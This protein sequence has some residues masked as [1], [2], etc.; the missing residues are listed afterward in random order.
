MTEGARL[1]L[2]VPEGMARAI[3]YAFLVSEIHPF[4]DGNG[5]L[6]RLLMNAELTRVG[7]ARVI[8]P[9]LFHPQYVDCARALTRKNDPT[10]FVRSIVKMVHWCNQFDYSDIDALIQA[11][12][13]T[14][15][16]EESPVEYKLL[17]R[18]G[19]PI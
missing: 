19:S 11:I 8:I 15:A 3:Y 12:R 14:N 1:A 4:D 16:L 6:S 5:R 10:G 2:S 18:E 9:T 17:N 7:L 13:N